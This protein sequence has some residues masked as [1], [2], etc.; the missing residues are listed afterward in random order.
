M[1]LFMELGVWVSQRMYR[2][3]EGL[4]IVA[5]IDFLFQCV[6]IAPGWMLLL[7]GS[8][9]PGNVRAGALY[10]RGERPGD[11]GSQSAVL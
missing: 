6:R 10:L 2:S 4:A 9:I 11:M 1:L 5:L 3:G 8:G 7:F